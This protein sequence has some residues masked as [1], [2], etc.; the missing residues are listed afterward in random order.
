MTDLHPRREGRTVA[1]LVAD[2]LVGLGVDRVYGLCG[3]HIQPLWDTIARAGI[4]VVDVR[5]EC[6]AV[7][8][9]HADAALRNRLGVALVTAGP[10]VTNAMTGIANASSARIPVLVISGRTPRPQEGM[11]AMQGLPHAALVDPICRRVEA[12]SQRHRVVPS[13]DAAVQAAIG[14]DGPPGPAYVDFATDLLDEA[15][16]P[17]D[18]GPFLVRRPQPARA[19]P[20]PADVDAAAELIAAAS[21]PVVISGRTV[22]TARTALPQFLDASGALHLDTAESRGAL[23]ADH[24]A[25]VP[26][27]RSRVM[28]EADLVITLGRRLDFQLAYGS[29]AVFSPSARFLRVGT[30]FEDL[31]ENRRGDVELRADVASGL[32]A[33]L[34]R[35]TAPVALDIAWRDGVV[36]ENARRAETLQ[37][38]MAASPD[39]EDGRMHPYRLIAALNQVI[40]DDAIVI[41]DGGDILSFARVGLKTPT[42]LDPGPLGCLGVAVPFAVAAALAFPRRQVIALT[43]DGSLGFTAMELDSAARHGARIV[44]VVANNDAWNIERH[45]QLQ[46]YDGNLVGVDLPDCRYGDLASS[47]G[48]H[49][50]RVEDLESLAGA[51]QRAFHH[52][53]A[54]LDVAVTRDALSPDF[55]SGLAAVPARHAL[56]T[57]DEAESA[58]QAAGSSNRSSA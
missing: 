27:M 49:G 26:A 38:R 1:G 30:T 20:N 45:D 33:L 3:G 18:V 36:A 5:H 42:Y 4:G 14:A 37:S 58:L 25:S 11:G 50:E 22:L 39:G 28:A 8:M 21:R 57:W 31:S 46:R 15:V 16:S 34:G 54:L 53:P 29:P 23:P 17:A 43:G 7:Y 12:V 13:L 52:A 55:S 56:R 48:V 9:A 44:V 41:A 6:A 32:T 51:I 19:H 40:D 10:G 24:R 35:I 47:L 2:Y